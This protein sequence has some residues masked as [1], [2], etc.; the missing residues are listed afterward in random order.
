MTAI[1][2]VEGLYQVPDGSVN[3]YL[4]ESDD[5]L[6]LVDTGTDNG[7][8]AVLAA[9]GDLGRRPGDL[10]HILLTHWHSDHM[11]SAAALKRATGAQVYAHPVDAPLIRTGG[12]IDLTRGIPRAF[13]VAPGM[14]ELFQQLIAG[15]GAIQ[16]E[17][18]AVDH[19]IDEGSSLPFLPDLE[20]IFTPGHSDG[21]VVFLWGRQGGVLLGG[22][23]CAN[24]FGLSWSLGYEDFDAGKRSLKKLC[25]YDFEVATFGH[26]TV[27]SQNAAAQWRDAW[28]SLAA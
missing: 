8:D 19:E 18:V 27:I 2:I 28:G 16:V 10:K 3:T 26:G 24:A 1:P 6:V 25:N 9:L 23:I 15:V 4:L 20:V 7:V 17:G 5:G 13:Q 22:D 21:H 12:E 14:D 11:G